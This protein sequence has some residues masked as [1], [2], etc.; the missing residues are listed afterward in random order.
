M[1][2]DDAGGNREVEAFEHRRAARIGEG[3]IAEADLARGHARGGARARGQGS[4]RLHRRLE[5]QHGGDRRR[6][7]IKAQLSPPNAIIDVPTALWANMTSWPRS[8]R[9]FDRGMGE[10]P[11]HDDVGADHQQHAPQHRPL[12]QPRRLVLQLVQPRAAV[13]EAIDRPVGQSEQP[14]LLARRRI[15]GEPVGVIG[16]AL[17]AAHF[18][19]VAVAPDRRF[20]AAANASPARRRRARSAPTRRKRPARRPTPGRRSSRPGRWR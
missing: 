5:A 12:A 15:D 3:D 14:Q 9:P 20:R 8:R 16:V 17:G 10:R 7:P 13:D 19:G 4:G 1:A 11:E 2:S 18:V 6:G